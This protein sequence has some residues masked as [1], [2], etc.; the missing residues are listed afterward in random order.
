MAKQQTH[1]KSGGMRKI[2]RAARKPKTAKYKNSHQR[3]RNKLKRVLQSNG[4]K[5]AWRF[6]QKNGVI[7]LYNKLI[8][9]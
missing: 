7:D 3:E 4:Q 8:A 2:G 9:K 5:E 1:K 6:A